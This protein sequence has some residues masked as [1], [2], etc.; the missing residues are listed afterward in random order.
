MPFKP[1]WK[2]SAEFVCQETGVFVR[3]TNTNHKVPQWSIAGFGRYKVLPNG[4]QVPVNYILLRA[5]HDNVLSGE[6]DYTFFDAFQDQ[7]DAAVDF[8]ASEHRL[9]CQHVRDLEAEKTNDEVREPRNVVKVSKGSGR[10]VE[11][12]QRQQSVKTE[13]AP[14]SAPE[15]RE[16]ESAEGDASYFAQSASA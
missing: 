10:R 13:T 3:V 5:E 16:D 6:L 7:V 9:A 12:R 4:N 11:A 15:S 14:E 8:I 1:T 2:E